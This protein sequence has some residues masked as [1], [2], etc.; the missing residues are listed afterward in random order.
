MT[1]RQLD[2][3]RIQ[4][5]ELEVLGRNKK[6]ESIGSIMWLEITN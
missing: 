3:R 5:E 6:A 2:S 4:M 1:G